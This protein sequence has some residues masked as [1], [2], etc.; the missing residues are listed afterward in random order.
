M[1]DNDIKKLE[2]EYEDI[3]ADRR[4]GSDLRWAAREWEEVVTYKFRKKILRSDRV[5]HSINKLVALGESRKKIEK[6][7]AYIVEDMRHSLDIGMIRKFAVTL[8]KIM[9]LIY[10]KILVNKSGIEIIK[11]S[12]EDAPILFL[13]THR[14]YADF[15]LISYLT[16][17]YNLPFPVIAA[18]MDFMSMAFIGD[19]LRG[20]GAFYIRRSFMDDSL[21][22]AVFQEYVQSLIC[23]SGQPMEF[24]LE[25]TRSRRLLGCVLECWIRAKLP[26]ITIVPISISYNRTLEEKLYAYEM[27][28]VPKPKE[29]TSGL[30]KA[31]RILKEKFGTI[32]V[33]IGKGISVSKFLSPRVDRHLNV[34]PFYLSSLSPKEF[35]ACESLAYHV[36]RVLQ[37]N[38]VVSV[39]SLACV[40]L[41]RALWAGFWS[42]PFDTLYKETLNLA[43]LAKKLGALVEGL[44]T[45]ES[46][47]D[48]L[49]RSLTEHCEVVSLSD[50]DNLVY[51]HKIHK[52]IADS[53]PV[54]LKELSFSSPTT[55]ENSVTHLLLQYYVNQI[56]HLFI[57]PSLVLFI[58]QNSSSATLS[59]DDVY[60]KFFVLSSIFSFDFIFESDYLKQDVNDALA[61]LE[62][63]QCVIQE[64]KSSHYFL[65]Q[66]KIS[67]GNTHCEGHNLKEFLAVITKP[68]LLNYQVALQT[69]E[70]TRVWSDESSVVSA[71]QANIEGPASR[72]CL[73]SSLSLDTCRQ[74][75][76]MLIKMDALSKEKRPDGKNELISNKKNIEYLKEVLRPNL[77]L[78]SQ[79]SKL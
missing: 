68:F 5:N 38:C 27:L 19:M 73:Y 24:F 23:D 44:D 45:I 76:K 7:V 15:L 69:I 10:N 57:R 65:T 40:G 75:V 56:L 31:M 17:H 72:H 14:S 4:K 77:I 37:N 52:E 64:A 30:L 22:W 1:S 41:I 29:S 66:T 78:E 13:P 53:K 42:L 26:D 74:A 21:Y 46:I 48:H 55:V 16:Y 34:D 6:K 33:H 11:E 67:K 43:R 49:R 35:N 58:F 62:D 8:P 47:E 20:A 32:Y 39:W 9:K 54:R 63:E 51:I 50:S 2:I 60:Q 12:T 59:L 25:G 3:L 71:I 18:G 61:F 70:V 28:G 36:I 79:K